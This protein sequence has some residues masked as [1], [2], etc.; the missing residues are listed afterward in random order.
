M[1]STRERD[2]FP[3]TLSRCTR[4]MFSSTEASTSQWESSVF[5][6][7]IKAP[8]LMI[9]DEYRA[10]VESCFPLRPAF[11]T[12]KLDPRKPLS[13]PFS[14]DFAFAPMIFGTEVQRRIVP[15]ESHGQPTSQIS[16]PGL[17][18]QIKADFSHFPI[19]LQ[20]SLCRSRTVPS[21]IDH[22]HQTCEDSIG[23]KLDYR[24]PSM[25]PS[26]SGSCSLLVRGD[27]RMV[28]SSWGTWANG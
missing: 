12:T 4:L 28:N 18:P 27:R 10:E 16:R 3:K 21:D 6:S 8:A 26:S 24:E 5:V 19:E 7:P 1:S 17:L 11:W 23:N 22:D 15:V 9:L 14:A 2:A 13:L 20:V 25:N